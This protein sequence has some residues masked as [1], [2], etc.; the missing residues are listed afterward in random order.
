MVG[1]KN[2]FTILDK[3]DQL[4]LVKQV[5]SLENLDPKVYVPKNFLYMIDQVKNAGLETEDVDN[6]EFEIETKGK[7]KQ[8]YKSYQSR[9]SNY[10]SVDFGDLI[11]LPIK[12][13]KENK[14]NLID[15]RDI[16]ELQKEGQIEGANH[17]PRGMLEFWLD[18]ES[19]YFKEGKLDLNKEMVLFCAGGLRSAL[20]TKS[21]QEMGFK[22]ISHI[23]GGFSALKQSNFKILK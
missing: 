13:F 23:D 9:L 6:H 21:L 7:F 22:K 14:C 11:L 16:R 12:L 15:I 8:I 19:V 20:A 3:D 18:P 17:I 5:I 1:L 2:D 4:R 10:N